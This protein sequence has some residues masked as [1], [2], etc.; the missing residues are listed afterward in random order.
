MSFAGAHSCIPSTFSEKMNPLQ[1]DIAEPIGGIIGTR[2]TAVT[3]RPLQSEC[4]LD[5]IDDS[6]FYIGGEVLL[7]FDNGLSRYFSWAEC[8]SFES[9][10]TLAVR[11]TSH[12]SEGTLEDLDASGTRLWADTIDRCLLGVRCFGWDASPHVLELNFGSA[13][14]LLGSSWR[15]QFG[16]A[17]DVFFCDGS[18]SASNLEGSTLLWE[19]TNGEQVADDQLPARVESKAE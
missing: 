5:E 2:L 4:A 11:A 3:Y 15:T 6:A 9:H 8:G 7:R 16:D 1:R 13:T 19:S 17:D 10:F 18:D 12:F 14:R